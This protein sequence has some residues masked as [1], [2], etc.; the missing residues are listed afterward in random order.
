MAQILPHPASPEDRGG[1]EKKILFLRLG[2]DVER[3]NDR[4]GRNLGQVAVMAKI[5]PHPASPEDR[6][7]VKKNSLP[8]LRERCL[9]V[10]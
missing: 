3:S 6:G 5:L 4:E 8:T 9:S 2:R 10:G 7:G 1:V